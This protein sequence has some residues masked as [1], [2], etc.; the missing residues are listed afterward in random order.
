M[1]RTLELLETLDSINS[2]K[3]EQVQICYISETQLSRCY[4]ADTFTSSQRNVK[5]MFA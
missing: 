2:S 1:T 5:K 3:V 4:V